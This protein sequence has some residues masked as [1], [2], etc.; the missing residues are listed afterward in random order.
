[1][2][3]HRKITDNGEIVETL[4]ESEKVCVYVY[5]CMSTEKSLTMV[6]SSR[7]FQRVSFLKESERVVCV[8]IYICMYTGKSL[9][10]V[11]TL[12]ESERVWGCVYVPRKISDDENVATPLESERFQRE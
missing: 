12:P 4:L 9:T 7:P 3:V 2:Y 11:E 10:M 6:K 1:M 5:V 8:C